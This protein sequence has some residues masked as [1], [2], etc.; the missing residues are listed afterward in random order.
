[1]SS[2]SNAAIS[3]T[4][5]LLQQLPHHLNCRRGDTGS[6]KSKGPLII[7]VK[8]SV[9]FDESEVQLATWSAGFGRILK[10]RGKL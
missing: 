4:A 7:K 9:P 6:L 1:M 3:V 10:F 8:A 5:G 2:D